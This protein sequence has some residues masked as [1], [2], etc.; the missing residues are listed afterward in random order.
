MFT[1]TA[2]TLQRGAAPLLVS[3][4]HCGVAIPEEISA[5]L[6]EVARLSSDTDWYLGALYR[7]L[8]EG[9][10]VTIISAHYS[11]YVIDLNRP[12]NDRSTSSHCKVVTVK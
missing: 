1:N 2:Y 11:R 10:D 6:T 5:R 3:I 12:A 7:P 9:R 8:L 4:P